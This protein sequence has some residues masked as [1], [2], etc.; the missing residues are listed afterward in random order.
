MLRQGTGSLGVCP[1][2]SGASHLPGS[3]PGRSGLSRTAALNYGS[4]RSPRGDQAA[5]VSRPHQLQTRL[6]GVP[7]RFPGF[8]QGRQLFIHGGSTDGP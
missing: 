4:P 6:S 3:A 5:A 1:G 7:G 8:P 2:G